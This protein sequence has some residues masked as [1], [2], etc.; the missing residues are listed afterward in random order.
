MLGSLASAIQLYSGGMETGLRSPGTT[1]QQSESR[2]WGRELGCL[3]KAVTER[4]CGRQLEGWTGG[5]MCAGEGEGTED[6]LGTSWT[7]KA[8]ITWLHFEVFT[9]KS[10]VFYSQL[11]NSTTMQVAKLAK[12][13]PS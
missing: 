4:Q 3:R 9:S 1:N 5:K 10:V 7:C 2:L 13:L 12:A 11:V 6:S 8:K